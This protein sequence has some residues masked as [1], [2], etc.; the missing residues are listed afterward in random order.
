MTVTMII[1]V[2]CWNLEYKTDLEKLSLTS[3]TWAVVIKASEL[4]ITNDTRVF[5]KKTKLIGVN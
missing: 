1:K 4:K 3:W 2:T 5:K